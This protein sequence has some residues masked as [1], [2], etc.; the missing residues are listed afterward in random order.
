[1]MQ[2]GMKRWECDVI[3]KPNG[4]TSVALEA[5]DRGAAEIAARVWAGRNGYGRDV[6]KR[7]V[8]RPAGEKVA[9]NGEGWG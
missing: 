8:V 3:L 7:V 1:M 2:Q 5:R 9:P 6:V 4:A